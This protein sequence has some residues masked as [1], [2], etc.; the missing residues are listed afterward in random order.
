MTS[1]GVVRIGAIRYLNA[2]PFYHGL[3]ERLASIPV[4]WVSGVP[5]E[6]NRWMREGKLDVALISSLEY[7]RS[8]DQYYV[9]ND[10]CIG[11][12][13]AAKSVILFSELPLEEL[14]GRVISLSEESLSSA[15]LLKII[16]KLKKGFTNVYR[17]DLRDLDAMLR[18]SDGG[19][20]IGDQALLFSSR[21]DLNQFDLSQAWSE[22]QMLPFCFALWAV[23]RT[24]ADS[25]PRVIRVVAQE[26]EVNV[27][28]N[29]E[30]L[31][32]MVN[33]IPEPVRRTFGHDRIVRY[34][35]GLTYRLDPEMLEGLECFYE[36]SRQMGFLAK[37]I[38]LEYAETNIVGTK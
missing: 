7:A 1:D 27:N 3:K 17:H 10:Y 20:V 8:A 14:N 12:M 30:A 19:L 21:S 26:L 32:D 11:S 23:R 28:K 22:W 35:E 13:G 31:A 18:C 36:L 33:Q 15:S 9:L 2:L 6:L 5:T 24:F 38:V 4:D 25:Y 37:E 16:L 34:L 29:K